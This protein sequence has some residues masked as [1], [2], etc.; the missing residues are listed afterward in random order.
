MAIVQSLAIGKSYKSA[1]N[2]TYKTVRGRTIASQRITKN[3]SNSFAQSAQRSVFARTI[4]GMQLVLPWVNNFFEKSK[5]GSSRNSFMKLCKGRYLMGGLTGEVA[6]GIV[7]LMEGFLLGIERDA[8]GL[9]ENATAPSL[10]Y[11]SLTCIVDE[12]KKLSKVTIGDTSINVRQSLSTLYT[13]TTAPRVTDVSILLYGF[14]KA[15]TPANSP[16]VQVFAKLQ[17]TD[18]NI[19]NIASNY[20]IDITVVKDDTD[21]Y[22]QSIKI[23]NAEEQPLSLSGSVFVAIPSF[24]GKIPTVTGLFGYSLQNIG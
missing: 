8:E 7:P 19:T 11:G 21:T 12:R 13:F 6:E 5:Y 20:G 1:G 9:L 4:Q 18:A 16:Y 2:L 24:G 17:L 3:L 10:S 22:V 15:T 23:E 14:T